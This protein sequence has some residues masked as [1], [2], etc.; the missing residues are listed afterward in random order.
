MAYVESRVANEFCAVSVDHLGI[1]RDGRIGD[2]LS[3]RDAEHVGP[4]FHFLGKVWVIQGKI[5]G[6]MVYL[7]FGIAPSVARIVASDEISPLLRSL[8][9]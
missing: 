3:P 5:G 6:S 9:R 7:Q 8:N 2:V 1:P 4:L